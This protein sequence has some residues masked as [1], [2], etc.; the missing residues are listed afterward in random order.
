M[1]EQL[2]AFEEPKPNLKPVLEAL[3]LCSAEPLT[4]KALEGILGAPREELLEALG[5][6]QK[7]YPAQGRGFEIW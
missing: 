6:L 3:L 2:S 5:G 7:D 4:L 1:R